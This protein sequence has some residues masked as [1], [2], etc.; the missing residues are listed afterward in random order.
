[1]AGLIANKI[2]IPITAGGEEV[3]LVCRR[4][5]AVETS[6]FLSQRFTAQGR[7]VKSNLYAA[8]EELM[9]KVLVDVENAQYETKAQE[10]KPLTAQAVLSDEDKAYW[11]GILGKPVAS[12]IDLIPLSWLSS[13]AMYFEDSA[14]EDAEG[15]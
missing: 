12:W 15:N 4:P 9:R 5:T 7:K 13:G 3:I 2:R 10:L 14:P 1:M 8:R 11:S 6:T